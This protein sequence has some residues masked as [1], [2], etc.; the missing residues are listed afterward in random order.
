MLALGLNIQWGFTGLFNAGIAGFFAVRAYVSA[1]LTTGLRSINWAGSACRS[2][3]VS[4]RPCSQVASSP[5]ASAASAS[6]CAAT[7]SRSLPLDRRDPPPDLQERDLGDQRRA[8]HF[9]DPQAFEHLPEPWNQ[10]AFMGLVLALVAL[11]YVLLEQ[12]RR[13]PGAA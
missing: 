8:R 3:R 4:R 5:G 9:V 11:L 10:L 13:A 2:Q 7:T 1:I 12:A 6:V